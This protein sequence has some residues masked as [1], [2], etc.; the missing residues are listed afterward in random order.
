VL[1]NANQKIQQLFTIR[2]PT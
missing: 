2:D 1:N